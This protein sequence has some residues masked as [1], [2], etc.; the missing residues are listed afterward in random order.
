M[1]AIPRKDPGMEHIPGTN[2][3]SPKSLRRVLQ[4]Q[5]GRREPLILNSS[6][7]ATYMS[8]RWSGKVSP[9]CTIRICCF[10]NSSLDLD[11]N[12]FYSS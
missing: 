1:A 5:F 6:Q 9:H 11:K 10:T 12:H 3:D 2:E 4:S 8:F 7:C